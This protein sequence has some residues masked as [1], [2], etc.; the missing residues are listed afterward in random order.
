MRS[1]PIVS[2]ALGACGEGGRPVFVEAHLAGQGHRGVC[3]R[4]TNDHCVGVCWQNADNSY[5]CVAR[6]ASYDGA[7]T[8]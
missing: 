2:I 6:C 3:N 4:M 1:L 5:T 7:S 8:G